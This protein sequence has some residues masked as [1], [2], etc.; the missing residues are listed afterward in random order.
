MKKIWIVLLVFA[1]VIV[2]AACGK[3]GNVPDDMS[4]EE[5]TAISAAEIK[6]AAKT[7]K[8][9]VTEKREQAD[10]ITIDGV[11][12]NTQFSTEY[13]HLIY[14][15]Y[16]ITNDSETELRLPELIMDEDSDSVVTLEI[17]NGT[18]YDDL[19]PFN[20]WMRSAFE[21]MDEPPVS[22]GD[23]A[24]IKPGESIRMV[25]AFQV[26]TE[27]LGENMEMK[28]CVHVNETDITADTAASEIRKMASADQIAEVL[29]K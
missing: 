28:I 13:Q 4:S 10:H 14:V 18:V 22:S 23:G 6:T 26:N 27:E 1:A 16:E 11:Y 25:S 9:D 21:A 12:L 7:K 29:S 2:G 19:L 17:Q 5:E 24:V 15:V 8:K 20:K 3:S